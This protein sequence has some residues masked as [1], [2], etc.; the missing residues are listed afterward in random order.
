MGIMRQAKENKQEY[1][2]YL[3]LEYDIQFPSLSLGSRQ[4]QKKARRPGW[5]WRGCRQGLTDYSASYLSMTVCD[6]IQRSL[7]PPQVPK[8]ISSATAWVR[9]WKSLK[10]YHQ[11][12]GNYIK[13][14]IAQHLLQRFIV[15][16][17]PA[18]AQCKLQAKLRHAVLSY[19][20]P[21][22]SFLPTSPSG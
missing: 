4:H 11:K 19:A 9:F 5:S 21:E 13:G 6:T 17:S 14:R 18:A 7:W 16:P 8:V 20:Q 2:R 3:Y 15:L 1:S 10:T 22:R 12:L